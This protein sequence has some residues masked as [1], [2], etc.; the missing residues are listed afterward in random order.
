M[1]YRPRRK[2]N[3]YTSPEY[4][5]K[6]VERV[7]KERIPTKQLAEEM[8]VSQT[9]IQQWVKQYKDFG[10]TFFLNKD[11]ENRSMTLVDADELKRLQAIEIAFEEQRIQVE[12]LKKF[13]TFLKQK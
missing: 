11:T 1:G 5:I 4:K 7:L 12:I 3:I 13:Q 2:Q 6:A 8:N 9:S 10:P